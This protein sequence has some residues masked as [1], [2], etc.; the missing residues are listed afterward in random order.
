M[1]LALFFSS[2]KA[3]W[4]RVGKQWRIND[5][6]AVKGQAELERAGRGLAGQGLG[7]QSQASLGQCWQGT[8]FSFLGITNAVGVTLTDVLPLQLLKEGLQRAAQLLL[9]PMV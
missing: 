6:P 9:K 2:L 5:S 4:E 7:Q 3:A 1:L 8:R